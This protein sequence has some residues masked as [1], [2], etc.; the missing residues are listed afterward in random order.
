MLYQKSLRALF[1]TPLHLLI[2]YNILLTTPYWG[3]SGTM[4]T[5]A[6]I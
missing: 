2:D 4:L 5:K 6:E 1:H 3:F